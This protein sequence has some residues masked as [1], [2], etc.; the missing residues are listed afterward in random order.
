MESKLIQ[1]ID[2][3]I[4]EI[5]RDEVNRLIIKRSNKKDSILPE[6]NSSNPAPEAITS[7]FGWIEKE[8]KLIKLH[9]L[10]YSHGFVLCEYNAFSKHFIGHS[11]E[12]KHIKFL[13]DITQLV[14]LF[15]LLMSENYIPSNKKRHKLLKE[16][17]IDRYGEMLDGDCL[18]TILNRLNSNSSGCAV[19]EKILDSLKD[20][21]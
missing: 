4:R 17:F 8:R 12:L 5:V 3:H 11:T 16:H 1:Q 10:L 15:D 7:K 20:D 9:H 21:I 14:Y 19:I 2:T 13:A 6:N 18:R